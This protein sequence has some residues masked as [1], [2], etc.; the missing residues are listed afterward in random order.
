M[1][2]GN[3]A[4][5]RALES[6][7]AAGNVVHERPTTGPGAASAIARECVAE[8]AD[9]ILA[10][11]GD[12][13]INEVINGMAHSTVPLAIL[14]GGTANVLAVELG[15][16]RRLDHATAM[17]GSCVPERVSLGLLHPTGAPPR[18]FLLM[19]G[20]GL[21]AHIVYNLNL[22]LKAHLGK[23]SYWLSGFGQLGRRLEQFDVWVDGRRHRCS[24]AL[25]SRVRNYGGDIEIARSACLLENNFELVLFEGENGFRYLKY[26][27]G[28]LTDSL[29]GMEGVVILPARRARFCDPADARVHI[30]VDGEYAGKLP[31]EIELVEN[32]LTLL[33]PADFRE[34]AIERRMKR[35]RW[36]RETAA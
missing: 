9:L 2:S 31:A 1:R 20:I 26:F 24:F 30:Q 10:A 11:G 35:N 5:T 7:R 28:V 4:L 27:A 6:L 34:R 13:T 33:V 15:L 29:P 21:D 22:D 23:L 19:A 18:Y 3:R 32:A 14:P 17:L 36:P 12:G 16:G 8:G 25:A